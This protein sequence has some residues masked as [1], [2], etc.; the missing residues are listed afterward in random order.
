LWLKIDVMANPD[1][2]VSDPARLGRPLT[3]LTAL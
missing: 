3:T 1:G 2:I